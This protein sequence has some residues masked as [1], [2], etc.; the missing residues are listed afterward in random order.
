MFFCHYTLQKLKYNNALYTYKLLLNG[1]SKTLLFQ[2]IQY[3][4][5]ILYPYELLC[6]NY[7]ILLEPEKAIVYYMN[8]F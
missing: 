5:F 7:T 6:C 8:N 1:T 3:S 2:I 4:N